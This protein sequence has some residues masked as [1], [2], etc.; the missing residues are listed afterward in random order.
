VENQL[1]EHQLFELSIIQ[2]Q[3]WSILEY[4]STRVRMPYYSISAK[5][6]TL[7]QWDYSIRTGMSQFVTEF[8]E[9]TYQYKHISTFVIKHIKNIA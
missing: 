6:C 5:L 9:T 7:L 2:T 8:E 1:S 3:N 4:L